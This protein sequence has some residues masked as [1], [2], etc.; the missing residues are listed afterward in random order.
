MVGWREWSTRW[1]EWA[2]WRRACSKPQDRLKL[3]GIRDERDGRAQDLASR[4]E[5]LRVQM[6]RGRSEANSGRRAM[7]RHSG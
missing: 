6:V 7:T 4:R 5:N 1:G 2:D 3:N